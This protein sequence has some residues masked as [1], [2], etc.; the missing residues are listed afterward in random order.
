ML[1]FRHINNEALDEDLKARREVIDRLKKQVALLEPQPQGATESS[2]TR[3]Q[4]QGVNVKILAFANALNAVINE[5]DKR[6]NREESKAIIQLQEKYNNLANY[7][8]DITFENVTGSEKQQVLGDLDGYI[9][10]LQYLT[11]LVQSYDES[12]VVEKQIVSE[13]FNQFNDQ[14]YQPIGAVDIQDYTNLEEASGQQQSP[15]QA[16]EESIAELFRQRDGLKVIDKKKVPVEV[17]KKI[18]S[19]SNKI[20]RRIEKLNAIANMNNYNTPANIKYINN[21]YDETT[22]FAAELADLQAAYESL[23]APEAPQ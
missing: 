19:L 18:A 22:S 3:S 4:I 15:K 13:I 16:L 1:L 23:N 10:Q 12:T 5:F 7:L 21:T 11:R 2:I 17:A 20:G 14:T 8:I 9:P 6:S